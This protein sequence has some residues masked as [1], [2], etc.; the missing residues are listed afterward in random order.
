MLNG[1]QPAMLICMMRELIPGQKYYIEKASPQKGIQDASLS[2][3]AQTGSSSATDCAGPAPFATVRLNTF[4]LM[5]RRHRWP[6]ASRMRLLPSFSF[7]TW[8]S[9]CKYSMTFY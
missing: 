9:T 2:P 7:R 4:P 8:F 3:F 1:S 6:S 5:A